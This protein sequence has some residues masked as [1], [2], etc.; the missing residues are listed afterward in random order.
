[1]ISV[2]SPV[3]NS[4]S[5]LEELVNKIIIS[6][7]KIT[8]SPEIILV[9]DGSIDN[10]WNKI[11]QLK[12]KFKFLK[13]IKLKKNFGQHHAIYF[14]IKNSSN[15][16]I[17][18]MDCDLQDNPKF[19]PIMYEKYK[20]KDMPV[21]I[22]HSYE[23]FTAS[24]RIVSYFFW[25]F[26]SLI[27]LKK[28]SAYLGNYLLIDHKIKKKYLSIKEI[29]YLYGDLISQ[30]NNFEIIEK[31]RS[32]SKR[33]V[34]TYNYISLVKFSLSLILK[35]NFITSFFSTK[36]KNKIKKNIIEKII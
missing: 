28:F 12:K 7:K 9:D 4:E 26:L 29:G 23:N 5:C 27:S 15:N 1:M 34:S 33:N 32:R 10:S 6:T 11:V 20:K 14:G 30:N 3:Y 8:K 19:I 16:I 25:Q 13:G 2:V 17:I 18:I 24:S 21:I 31:K 22:Q 36:K 35:Y